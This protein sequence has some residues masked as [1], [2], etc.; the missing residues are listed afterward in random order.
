MIH[1]V[2]SILIGHRG[3]IVS[4][5]TLYRE[6]IRVVVLRSG[7]ITYYDATKQMMCMRQRTERDGKTL[8]STLLSE[9]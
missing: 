7:G 2:Y 9:A 8:Y 5:Y 3:R 4:G 1:S 6:L